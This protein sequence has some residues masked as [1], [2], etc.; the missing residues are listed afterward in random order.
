MILWISPGINHVKKT[1]QNKNF[2]LNKFFFKNPQIWLFL[3]GS[4]MSYLNKNSPLA[5]TKVTMLLDLNISGQTAVQ[6]RI[7]SSL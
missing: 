1:K 6:W 2:V 5:A 3:D 4:S 7:L